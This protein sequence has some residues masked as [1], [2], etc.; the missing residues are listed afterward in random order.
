MNGSVMGSDTTT[1]PAS[2]VRQDVAEVLRVESLSLS[3]PAHRG[4][5]SV[6]QDAS[7]RLI[8][9]EVVGIVGETGSGKSLMCRGII[10]LLPPSI[11]VEEGTVVYRDSTVVGPG[12]A[13]TDRLRGSDLALIPQNPFASLNPAVR[14]SRQFRAMSVAHGQKSRRAC[15]ERAREALAAV[16]L[17]DVDRVLRSYPH[18][19]SGGMAQRVVIAL[20]TFLRPAIVFADEPTTGLDPTVQRGVLDA[21]LQV[22]REQGSSLV[23]ISHDLGV[24]HRY[25]DRAYVLY[26][27]N[28]VEHGPTERILR[29]PYHPYTAGLVASVSAKG[30]GARLGGSIPDPGARPEG[31]VFS[32][33]CTY[34]MAECHQVRPVDVAREPGHDVACHLYDSQR[35]RKGG[36]A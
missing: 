22:V 4:R 34:V 12:K 23:L 31:C 25:C 7:F 36:D 6:L 3:A 15:A 35:V 26:A 28:I 29:H 9:G 10:G 1:V 8:P 27:G 16:Q 32:D 19:L 2:G 17:N 14:I 30:S 24:I 20:A 5:A 13:T 18:E 33:R 21:L 11:K